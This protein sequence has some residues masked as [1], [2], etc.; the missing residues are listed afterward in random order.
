MARI[1][2]YVIDGTIVDGDK[3]IGSDANNDMQTKNYTVGDLVNYFAASIGGNF[4]VPYVG[5]NNDV[6]LGAFNLSATEISVSGNF[7]SDGSAGLPGQVLIS[8]GPG[9]PAIW[10]YSPGTQDLDS[11]LGYGN[12]GSNNINLVTINGYAKI[13]VEKV[14]GEP[15][16]YLHSTTLGTYSNWGIDGL[17]LE[18]PIHIADYLTNKIRYQFGGNYVDIIPNSY[19]NQAFYLPIYGGYIPIS[20]NGNFADSSGNIIVSGGGGGGVTGT[21]TTNYISKW[22]SSTALTDSSIFDNGTSVGIGTAT[23]NALNKLQVVGTIAT[24]SG[25][26]LDSNAAIK[27]G[28]YSGINAFT[29]WA[30]SNQLATYNLIGNVAGTSYFTHSIGFNNSGGATGTQNAWRITASVVDTGVNSMIHNQLLIDPQYVHGVLGTGLVRGVYYNPTIT[31]LNGADHYAWQNTSGDI[32]H[33]NLATGGAAQ[34]VTSDTNGKLGIQTIPSGGGGTVTSVAALT[35]GTTG[36]D[37]SSTVANSTTTP[38]ITLNVPDASATN[39]GALTSADYSK[40]SNSQ[41]LNGFQALGSTF[42]GIT[43]TTPDFKS[44]SF[45]AL[46]NQTL[47]LVPVYIPISTIITGVKFMQT[48]QGVYTANNYNGVGLYSHSG[49]TLTLVASSTNDGNFWKGTANTWQTKP[50]SSTYSAAVGTY[51]IGMLYNTSAQTT[52]PTISVSQATT[53]NNLWLLDLTNSNKLSS[54]VATQFSLPA[55]QAMSGANGANFMWGIFVY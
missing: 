3:V 10:G 20:V 39:R 22:S 42:K 11:V 7:I 26:N 1:S 25:I 44:T 40:F 2:T 9:S 53:G 4:L 31:S 33:G 6:D 12:T 30:G 50:F 15:A 51:Y 34:M 21:G 43:L 13:D 52:A 27:T 14:F 47:Y 46:S 18:S 35:L 49:G 24:T 41:S 32:I 28:I 36:T 8:Q 45:N 55:S 19:N 5:A 37:L 16:M 54:T 48:V 38:V 23:P 17:H 29:F